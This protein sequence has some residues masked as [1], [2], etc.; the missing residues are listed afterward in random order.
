MGSASTA[1]GIVSGGGGDGDR[2]RVVDVVEEP[3][4]HSTL[5]RREQRGQNEG[6]SVRLETDVVESEVERALRGGDERGCLARDRGRRLPA[7]AERGQLDRGQ[8]SGQ[9]AIGYVPTATIA[10][11]VLIRSR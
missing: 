9:K 8:G 1:T 4:V 3:D 5:L 10:D 2:P 11:L 6:A 7:F